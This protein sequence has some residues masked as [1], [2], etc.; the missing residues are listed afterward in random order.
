[1]DGEAIEE[2]RDELVAQL[3]QF[4]TLTEDQ[5]AKVKPI[6]ED[7]FNQFGSSPPLVQAL[8]APS[9]LILFRH[10]LQH[11]GDFRR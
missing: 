10:W 3:T 1:M 4:L 5:L 6:L 8:I 7:E 9:F 2:I 11:C